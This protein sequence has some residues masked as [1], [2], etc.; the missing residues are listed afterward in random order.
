MSLYKRKNSKTWWINLTTKDG[1]RI[2]QSTWTTVKKDAQEYHDIKKAE[3]W[4]EDIFD[5]SPKKLWEEC[6]LIYVD[7]QINDSYFNNIR[8]DLKF[9]STYLKGKS[10]NEINKEMINTIISARRKSTFIRKE[11]GT[12][13]PVST[14]T[15]NHTIAVLNSVLN[16]AHKK[17]F[18][19]T[20]S[21]IDKIKTPKDEIF[22]PHWLT[23]QE[24]E[25]LAN[26]LP[27][28]LEVACRFATST[29][30]RESNITL[31]EWHQ[32]N[33][34]SKI[35]HIPAN[36]SKNGKPLTI[37]LNRT[38][39]GI[40]NSQKDKHPT[41]VFTYENKPFRK[42]NTTSFKKA[43]DRAKI[44]PHSNS[45]NKCHPK[46]PLNEYK[47]SEFP[48]HSLRH[49]FASWHVEAGTPLPVLQK[50]GGWSSYDMVLIYAHLAPD[51]T[52]SFA[53]NIN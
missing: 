37:P 12:K 48:E 11:G 20:P 21:N 25:N 5:E 29:G 49:T 22:I 6:V 26:E 24:F 8:N 50:L 23:K 1:K 41:R 43:C 4:R 42:I 32:V 18:K 39:I 51:H 19:T 38:A 14:C 3:L 7:K 28:H 2:R 46:H 40:L 17:G 33:L 53:D 45:V 36:Q 30:L 13:Y 52:A 44:A 16:Y 10:V 35:V 34:T 9:I 31:L 15:V 27:A 47:Y